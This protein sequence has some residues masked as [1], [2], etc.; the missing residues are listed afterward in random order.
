VHEA[1]DASQALLDMF[2]VETDA[3]LTSYLGESLLAVAGNLNA[4]IRDPW[5]RRA[6]VRTSD[7]RTIDRASSEMRGEQALEILSELIAR[8]RDSSDPDLVH[9]A[10]EAQVTTAEVLGRL[11]HIQRAAAAHE[12]ASSF[13]TAAVSVFEELAAREQ[14]S[15]LASAGYLASALMTIDDIDDPHDALAAIDELIER[16]RAE[17][18]LAAGG[19]LAVARRR[20]AALVAK[21]DGAGG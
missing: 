17:K 19:L 6:L 7:R 1:I 20:R 2:R 14:P 4:W 12:D 13:G 10:A 11:G 9:Q 16:L 8:F 15:R 5:F 21:A 3:D 18:T